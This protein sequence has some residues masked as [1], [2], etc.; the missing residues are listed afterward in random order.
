MR[1]MTAQLWRKTGWSTLAAALLIAVAGRVQAQL[2]VFDTID[3]VG[4]RGGI[5]TVAVT[6]SPAGVNIN[7]FRPGYNGY[8][9]TDPPGGPPS[10]SSVLNNNPGLGVPRW[11][12]P[13]TSD[14]TTNPTTGNPGQIIVDNAT[15]SH[16]ATGLS[17][18][19]T[20]PDEPLYPAGTYFQDSFGATTRFLP[21][22][23][24]AQGTFDPQKMPHM[25]YGPIVAGLQW[26]LPDVLPGAVDGLGNDIDYRS[27]YGGYSI[28]SDPSFPWDQ[29]YAFTPAVHSDFTVTRSDGTTGPATDAE[30]AALPGGAQEVVQQIN[31]RLQVTQLK[32]IYSMGAYNAASG[33]YAVDVHIPGSG[34][35]INGTYHPSVTR[36]F[37]RVSW[38][39]SA[40]DGIYNTVGPTGNFSGWLSLLTNSRIYV[41]NMQAGGWFTLAAPGQTQAS[42]P[43]DGTPADQLVVTIYTLTPDD[44]NPGT[45]N[46]QN[47]DAT[48]LVTA[49]AV[50]FRPITNNVSGGLGL[51]VIGASG[52]IL[53][54]VAATSKFNNAL[55]SN[56]ATTEQLPLTYL[57]REETVPDPTVLVPQ[58]PNLPVDPNQYL[59][60]PPNPPNT[61]NPNYNPLIPD[62]TATKT[63]PVFYCI[64]NQN[65]NA[66]YGGVQITSI[67]KVRW[68]YEGL[69]D[70]N[71][72]L[73]DGNN[74]SVASP[75]IANVRCRDGAV[76]PMVYFVTT[77]AG[78][79]NGRIYAFDPVGDRTKLTTDLYWVYPSYRPLL[80]ADDN[81]NAQFAAAYYQYHDPNYKNSAAPATA[82]GLKFVPGTYPVST[83]GGAAIPD[84]V[85]GADHYYDGEVIQDPSLPGF[86]EVNNNNTSI[87]GIGGITGSPLLI[88]D[89]GNAS[90]PQLLVV[91]SN[92]GRMYAF[93]AGG[94]GDYAPISGAN[95]VPGTTQRLWTY[96]HFGA[97]AYHYLG[98]SGQNTI[99]DDTSKTGFAQTPAYD[100]NYVNNNPA[101]DPFF[102][103]ALDGHVYAINPIRDSI[104][105]PNVNGSQHANWN[106]ST[107]L[108]WQ[109]PSVGAYPLVTTQGLSDISSISLF[110]STN[111]TKYAYFTAAGRVYCLPE[112]A[113]TA[114]NTPTWIYPFTN[115]PPYPSDPNDTSTYDFG[116][117][118][119]ISVAQANLPGSTK[120]EVYVLDKVTAT[121]LQL[122][123]IGGAAGAT[124]LQA[125]GQSLSGSMT[126][127]APILSQL[128]TQA[129]YSTDGNIGASQ[130]AIIFGDSGGSL[131]GL[132][133]I[134]EV[135]NGV[136]TLSVIWS[137]SDSQLGRDA[138]VVLVNGMLLS[139]SED[140]QLRAYGV[141]TGI[142]QDQGTLGTGEPA[143]SIPGVGSLSIDLRTVNLYSRPDYNAIAL[144]PTANPPSPGPPSTRETPLRDES[145]NAY[146]NSANPAPSNITTGD[147]FAVDWGDYLYIVAAG[148]YHAHPQDSSK[149]VYGNNAPTIN[150]VFTL[151]Q[152]NAAPITIPASGQLRVSGYYP[153]GISSPTG[154]PDDNG[155]TAAEHNNL[156]I[157]GLGSDDGTMKTLTG[158][159]D[160]VYPW[161]AKVRVLINPSTR[162]PFAPGTSGYKVTA[163]ASIEQSFNNNGSV[164]DTTD[165]SN[166]LAAGE[167]NWQ[168]FDLTP[169]SAGGAIPVTNP[170]RL[171]GTRNIAIT[172]PI[173]LTVRS[174]TG[175]G[176]T[177]LTGTGNHNIIGWTGSVNRSP[178]NVGEIL[179]NG[180]RQSVTGNVAASSLSPIKDLFAPIGL[181]PDGSAA[182]YHAINSSRQPVDALYL[183][184]RSA[185]SRY[186]GSNGGLKVQVI[187]Q[188]PHWYGGPTSVMNP[189]PWEQLPL[190]N[191]ETADY[192]SLN[193]NALTITNGSGQDAI[194][195][196][197]TLAPPIFHDKNPT[198]NP[199]PD[200]DVIRSRKIQ[201]TLMRMQV[202]VPKYQPANVNRGVASATLPD[203]STFTFGQGFV[204]L[205]GLVHG[206][207]L[208]TTNDPVIGPVQITSGDPVN[209]GDALAF[210]AA[211]YASQIEVRVIPP[212]SSTTAATRIPG[213]TRLQLLLGRNG[214]N[215]IATSQE[216]HRDFDTGLTVP[217]SVRMR[218]QETT[219]DLGK[220]PHGTGYSDLLGGTYRIPFSPTGSKDA[221]LLAGVLNQPAPWDDPDS[222]S[223][224]QFFQPF[225]VISD[226]NVN[227]INPRVAKLIGVNGAGISAY[228]HSVTATPTATQAVALR[229]NSDQVNNLSVSPLISAAFGAGPGVGN[230]GVVSTLDHISKNNNP[231]VVNSNLLERAMWPIQNPYVYGSDVSTVN[232]ANKSLIASSALN[233][234]V[235][236]WADGIQPQPVVSKPRP[237]DPV[238]HTL[239]IPDKPHDAPDILTQLNSAAGPQIVSVFTTPKIGLAIPV[240]TPVGTYSTAV[241]V[242]EDNTPPQWREWLAA[243]VG[244]TAGVDNDNILN[245]TSTGSLLE[246]HTDPTFTLKATVREARL[247]QGWTNGTLP[248]VD[249]ASAGGFG[250]AN[251]LPA[252]WMAPGTISGNL[253][254]R[255]LWMYWTTNRA[256]TNTPAAN[257]AWTLAASALPAPYTYDSSTY[258]LY[259][260]DFNFAVTGANA[261]WWTQPTIFAGYGSGGTGSAA[262]TS[263]L[264]PSSQADQASATIG[265]FVP[266][267]LAGTVLDPTT[268]ANNPS[269]R[270]TNPAVT[271]SLDLSGGYGP[272]NASDKEAYLFWQGS[273]DK[274]STSATQNNA[275]V[276]VTDT[277]TFWQPIGNTGGTAG[278]PQGP[279]YS[280]PNDPALAK[281]SPR[282]LLVKLPAFNGYPAQKF[283]FLFWS[284]GSGSSSQMYYNVAS[285]TNLG[286][287]FSGNPWG[288][289]TQLPL[290]GA[291]TSVSDPYPVFRHVKVPYQSNYTDCID[292]VFT[293]TLRMRKRPEIL[294]ARYVIN[295]SANGTGSLALQAFPLVNQELMTR[296]GTTNTFA[297]RDA[298]WQLG[299]GTNGTLTP[300][301]LASIGNINIDY[302]HGLTGT[303]S[304]LNYQFTINPVTKAVVPVTVGGVPIGAQ[305]GKV[306]KA[307]GLITYDAASI[308]DNGNVI[309]A[310]RGISGGQIVVDP[311]SGTVTFPQVAPLI[312][313]SV[314]VS[315]SPYIMRLNTSRDDTN[316]VRSILSLSPWSNDPAFRPRAAADSPGSNV[317]PVVVFDRGPNPRYNLKYPQVVFNSATAAPE[318]DRMWVLYRK[319]D[320]SGAVKSTIYYKSMRLMVKLPRPVALGAPDANGNQQLWATPS[321][322][323]KTGTPLGAYE[324]DWVRGRIYFTEA[325]EGKI[326]AVS[327][328]YYNPATNSVQ[329][330][331]TLYYTVTWGDEMSS[332]QSTGD[333]SVAENP[334]PTDQAVSEGTVAAFKDPYLD[335]LWIFWSSTRSNT[336]D[337]YYETIAPQLYSTASNQH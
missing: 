310:N 106:D 292:I 93:D 97:D 297:S 32:A 189:L 92:D 314:L 102:V 192:P 87:A 245:I 296:V 161:V 47:Y 234:G 229:L 301:D 281:R 137:Q 111:G 46:P 334:L 12:F 29:D 260:G 220:L 271:Q 124:T 224:G 266:P 191:V 188:P 49:D 170:S 219:V 48:P 131:W 288:Q 162:S 265:T 21:A 94:R 119:V 76:R 321:V 56:I 20:P 255:Q 155:L 239:T 19:F 39:T 241:N 64:D 163:Q 116:A 23:T 127:S 150:V 201:P 2:P 75:L 250:G 233:L 194:H 59:P 204:G 66:Q 287:T 71:N 112:H 1:H 57:A 226:S 54:P 172:N 235:I 176:S 153:G 244:Y 70:S 197:V 324:V 178:A 120:D 216:A 303:Y 275:N 74:I 99:L 298:F 205:S 53:A 16:V 223:L 248:Q 257:A 251:T 190:D 237:G 126:T 325:D 308:D 278:A 35:L 322:I 133:A 267:F 236:G 291:L 151:T 312:T 6:G 107:R 98:R 184:D 200:T 61:V 147:I 27:P 295:R 145:G 209:A 110:Q 317:A 166:Y 254:P 7:A 4:D 86:W 26:Q 222:P 336:T 187:T 299:F 67:D 115:N 258:P 232:G 263:Y 218:V 22:L 81:T 132:R 195:S 104:G 83:Y 330:S 309:P 175:D 174:F 193:D 256:L 225:T 85:I 280:L 38:G 259:T 37:V 142:N 272:A 198:L 31:A 90:G 44:V 315:Y 154:W 148:V 199:D 152:P 206:A 58:N 185:I 261:E 268:P 169:A 80:A 249:G 136:P 186:N 30:I 318:L 3:W 284:A 213:T 273:V 130:P 215:A 320:P 103:P 208:S 123:A 129:I 105:I 319:N 146:S 171:T 283:L 183:T 95:P 101:G 264:F 134:P 73:I 141:G 173:G 311:V 227:L 121:V 290:P 28:N 78:L 69:P 246:S 68:R 230:I 25:T 165:Y 109:Y 84:Q 63:I 212:N 238:G 207:N 125:T 181:I 42:F 50:R 327:Y 247:T 164:V 307:S 329:S 203:G 91:P 316:V 138:N 270:L 15:R 33:N 279:T 41:V 285:S 5:A 300:S 157:Y 17:Y 221:P 43:Y 14:L 143:Q 262:T 196:T 210:P 36:A 253:D 306:D 139:G 77:S 182:T 108:N 294:M 11:V 286:A 337:L 144:G 10:I 177:D 160:S 96:P 113:L 8:M 65:G 34:T 332:T 214:T 45:N 305:I 277:R 89:P 323:A 117:M 328:S 231:S 243:S 62:V 122:D 60:S 159:T 114:A 140:G 269:L 51:G 333:E 240:G 158:P 52:Q 335:K 40:S 88:D 179:A 331:G 135:I 55:N 313:D 274:L 79:S 13:R 252:V 228:A 293:G 276:A 72:L 326:V 282:P 168:G 128:Q 9:I 242:F 289:D 167:T 211:G 118:P 18:N 217:P 100:P 24:G 302:V 180:N 82:F 149:K 304:H 202:Q 156:K